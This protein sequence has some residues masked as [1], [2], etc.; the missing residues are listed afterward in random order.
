LDLPAL[1]Y[2]IM[3]NGVTELMMMKADVMNHFE[4]IKVAVA[5]QYDGKT[6]GEIP[7]DEVNTKVTPEYK[8]LDGWNTDLHSVESYSQFPKELKEYIS[9][10]ENEVNVPVRIVSLGPDRNQTIFK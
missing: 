2:A 10:I 4:K 6:T 9:F 8:V 3:L 5:Y 7:F 1:K